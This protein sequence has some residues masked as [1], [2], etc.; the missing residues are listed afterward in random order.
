M[1]H[2]AGWHGTGDAQHEK[3]VTVFN[4]LQDEMNGENKQA[5]HLA[6]EIKGL[7]FTFGDDGVWMNTSANSKHTSLNLSNYGKEGGQGTIGLL[8][9]C[10]ETAKYYA[11]DNKL[12]ERDNDRLC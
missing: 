5:V 2:E 4:A 7:S 12:C 11:P 10:K 1:L 6:T 3:I 8:E 9:W